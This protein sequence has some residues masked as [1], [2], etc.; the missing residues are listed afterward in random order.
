MLDVCLVVTL[1]NVGVPWAQRLNATLPND[2]CHV[3]VV[4]DA[5]SDAAYTVFPSAWRLRDATPAGVAYAANWGV[6]KCPPDTRFVSFVDGDD[7]ISPDYV[8]ALAG[9]LRA[10]DGV[11]VAMGR[12]ATPGVPLLE[13]EAS[14]WERQAGHAVAVPTSDLFTANPL[15]GRRMHRRTTMPRFPEGCAHFEDNPFWWRTLSRNGTKVAL[16][17]RVVYYHSPS[18]SLA[19]PSQAAEMLWYRHEAPVAVPSIGWIASR[20]RDRRSRRVLRERLG[21]VPFR[22]DMAV[23]VPCHNVA[24]WVPD[25]CRRCDALV[26]GAA[27]RNLSVQL[28]FVDARS[29][30]GTLRALRA[31]TDGRPHTQLL[32]YPRGD[33][34]G[35]RVRNFAVPFVQG[36]Y[37]LFFDADDVLEADAWVRAVEVAR[38]DDADLVFVKYARLIQETAG[39]AWTDAPMFASDDAV[40]RH[41]VRHAVDAAPFINYPWTRI[42]RTSLLLRKHIHF[43]IHAAHNDV[44]YHWTT[45]AHATRVRSVDAVGTRHRYH[46]AQTTAQALQ[47][48]RSVHADLRLVH[49]RL[50]GASHDLREAFVAFV[51]KLLAWIRNKFHVAANDEVT[52]TRS[53]V[54]AS[55]EYACVRADA[56]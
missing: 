9:P 54:R 37:T 40:W 18:R 10:D 35:G 21:A 24:Q 56:P 55:D 43:G 39:D 28:V 16:V 31:Y 36:T 17:D 8:D 11:D 14:F 26:R 52:F 49:R 38:H 41:G 33:A 48:H 46:A 53:C 3:V 30:D 45:L 50:V 25:L 23:V 19:V 20:Q 29:D 13:S 5:S 47:R 15:P 22:Y 27:A 6:T 7:W 2:R 42:V 32:R 4:D 44:L 1:H 34:Y 51:D 12:Y